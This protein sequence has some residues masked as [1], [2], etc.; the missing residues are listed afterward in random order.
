MKKLFLIC[1]AALLLLSCAKEP[2]A[3]PRWF[4]AQYSCFLGS[5]AYVSNLLF[6]TAY[7]PEGIREGLCRDP[8]CAHDGSDGICPD[9]S[10]FHFKDLVTDGSSLYFSGMTAD[11]VTGAFSRELYSL[12]P[13]GS[14][15]RLI[16]KTDMTGSDSPDFKVG[17]GFLWFTQGQYDEDA[18]EGERETFSILRVPVAGG[19]P[20]MVG[21]RY[22]FAPGFAVSSDGKTLAVI[23]ASYSARSAE[24][25]A[26]SEGVWV[27]LTDMR[28]GEKTLVAPPAA[29]ERLG[30]IDWWQG[31]LWLRA[32]KDR[33]ISF[34]RDS[35]EAVE[36]RRSDWV[37]YRLP[38]GESKFV[39]I[40][41]ADSGFVFGEDAVYFTRTESEYL[42]TKPMPTGRP[43]EYRDTDFVETK[44]VAVGFWKDGG[45]TEINPNLPE[46][47]ENLSLTVGA[48]GILYASMTDGGLGYY[49]TGEIHAVRCAL[50][51]ETLEILRVFE[52]D[53]AEP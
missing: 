30:F 18:P 53:P 31:E 35:G 8:L 44:T 14:D 20:E 22:L 17:G 41:E 27:E 39:R 48:D 47:F 16:C 32:Q 5:A 7:T 10:Q 23:N 1:L 42:G 6:V 21:E 37:L 45:I 26:S 40:A 19:E 43:G 12:R 25:P 34:I 29:D 50:D 4:N 46:G 24:A 15:F 9:S 13:D 51:P 3:P 52:D 33:K 36:Q 49:E 38:A 28:T 2:P 11:S